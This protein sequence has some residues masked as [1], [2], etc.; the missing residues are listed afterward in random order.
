MLCNRGI[1]ATGPNRLCRCSKIGIGL[2]FHLL[3]FGIMLKSKLKKGK[4]GF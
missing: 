4:M 1:K 3:K 2:N